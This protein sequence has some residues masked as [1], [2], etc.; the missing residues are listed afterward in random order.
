MTR[1]CFQIGSFAFQLRQTSLFLLA[2]KAKLPILKTAPGVVSTF[3]LRPQKAI[4]QMA[5]RKKK[6]KSKT[7]KK[8]GCLPCHIWQATCFLS[9]KKMT[10]SSG[11]FWGVWLGPRVHLLNKF[12]QLIGQIQHLFS[13]G[14]KCRI[15]RRGKQL[16]DMV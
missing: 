3:R 1:N 11:P 2:G 15:L 8:T 4:F 6:Y 9:K 7:N 12:I 14:I 13:K 5:R 16:R 10:W